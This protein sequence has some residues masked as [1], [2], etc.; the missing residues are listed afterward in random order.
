[1]N[2]IWNTSPCSLC[3]LR[4][5]PGHLPE[6]KRRVCQ[7][8]LGPMKSKIQMYNPA[9]IMTVKPSILCLNI[10]SYSP[11]WSQ[12]ETPLHDGWG[13]YLLVSLRRK[14]P[15]LLP[16]ISCHPRSHIPSLR[17]HAVWPR[18]RQTQNTPTAAVAAAAAWGAAGWWYSPSPRHCLWGWALCPFC[19]GTGSPLG[20]AQI[21]NHHA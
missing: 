3:W 10:H 1:M 12:G 7:A 4:L 21:A 5:Q 9:G 19:T 13:L 15:Q 16:S 11:D 8:C 17:G 2:P 6:G 14:H 18:L 20:S